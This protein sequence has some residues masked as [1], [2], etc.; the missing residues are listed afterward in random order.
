M[1]EISKKHQ[2]TFD[3]FYIPY[4]FSSE[5]N[6]AYCFINFLHPLFLLDF[7]EDF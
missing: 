4:D 5:G 1:K 7:Y 2:G 3:F 6:K